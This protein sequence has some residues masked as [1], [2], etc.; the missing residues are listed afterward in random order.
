MPPDTPFSAS[1]PATAA[2]RALAWSVHLFSASG[3]ILAL[4]ALLAV[5]QKQWSLALLWLLVALVVD[6]VDGSF[7]RLARVK[8]RA[9]RVDGDTLDLVIDFLTYVFVPTLFLWHAGMFPDGWALWLSAAILLSS[10]YLFARTDMKTEDGYFRGFPSLW[11]LVVFY[12]FVLGAGHTAVALT[13]LLCAVLTFAPI[14]FVHPFRVRQFGI[15][16]P[17]LA[18]LWTATTALLLIPNLTDGVRSIAASASIAAAVILL[19]LGLL[20]TFGLVGSARA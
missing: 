10:L 1:T 20:R 19:A 13:V 9:G 12:L 2:Q 5:E 3:A 7:A 4:L 17:L 15:W 18:I 6:G 8:E 14:H 16:L 11:N